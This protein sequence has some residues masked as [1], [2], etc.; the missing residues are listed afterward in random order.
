MNNP[1]QITLSN[2]L[3]NN[4]SAPSTSD[5]LVQ[6]PEQELA[7]K[8]IQFS[9]GSITLDVLIDKH[10]QTLRLGITHA[11]QNTDKTGSAN[12]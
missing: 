9:K 7:A 6:L 12:I 10:W 1:T 3:V 8:N 4:Q 11:P 5:E 2:S